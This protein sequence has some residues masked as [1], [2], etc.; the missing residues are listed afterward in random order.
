MRGKLEEEEPTKSGK[1]AMEAETSV[2]N[3]RGLGVT[4][5]GIGAPSTNPVA[6]NSPFSTVCGQD[7]LIN[8]V[9]LTQQIAPRKSARRTPTQQ[10]VEC[11]CNSARVKQL[12]T[13]W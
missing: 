1:E 12:K 4:R 9:N 2:V 10:L 3:K 8:T 6:A 13:A 7:D 11:M 5:A